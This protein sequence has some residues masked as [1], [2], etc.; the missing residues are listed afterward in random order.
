MKN[1]CGNCTF[2]NII[3]IVWLCVFV[4]AC[5]S[6]I[7][8]DDKKKT[9]DIDPPKPLLLSPDSVDV[10]CFESAENEESFKKRYGISE[11]VERTSSY[12]TFRC[13]VDTTTSIPKLSLHVDLIPTQEFFPASSHTVKRI[14]IRIDSIAINGSERYILSHGE[15]SMVIAVPAKVNNRSVIVHDT[16]SIQQPNDYSFAVLNQNMVGEKTMLRLS[17]VAQTSSKIIVNNQLRIGRFQ[18]VIKIR[19]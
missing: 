18:G 7:D 15:I 19:C 9:E 8:I 1:S 6:P 3:L 13:L 16:V 17:L 4:P 11:L 5:K 2:I 10:Q 14:M 12:S